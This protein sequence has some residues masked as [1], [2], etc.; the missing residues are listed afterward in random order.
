MNPLSESKEV[1]K[2]LHASDGL[3]LTK[4]I[5]RKVVVGRWVILIANG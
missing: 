1:A 3:P 5:Q 4:V 2:K